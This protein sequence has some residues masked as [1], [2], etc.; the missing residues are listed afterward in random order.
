[1]A[2]SQQ[3]TINV[4]TKASLEIQKKNYNTINFG[5]I[6]I[7]RFNGSA[8]DAW[9]FKEQI[10]LLALS[11]NWP[12]GTYGTNPEANHYEGGVTHRLA[13]WNGNAN[14]TCT[15]YAPR[16]EAAAGAGGAGLGK[17]PALANRSWANLELDGVTIVDGV[18]T[19]QN[20]AYDAARVSRPVIIGRFAAVNG[21]TTN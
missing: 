17:P 15:E 11:F 7:P 21:N 20:N 1:M 2:S 9:E 18:V 12:T 6:N 5:G 8:I 14:W 10:K 13:N 16:V 3:Q 19:T 4:S